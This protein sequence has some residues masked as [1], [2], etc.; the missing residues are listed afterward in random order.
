ARLFCLVA[1]ILSNTIYQ[2][3]LSQDTAPRIVINSVGHSGK[4][5]NV[6]YTPDGTRIIS[7]S[8]DKSIRIWD[9]KSGELLNK[10]ES[11]IGTGPKGMLYTSA[12]TPDGNILAVSGYPVNDDADNYIIFIDLNTGKQVSTAIG[13][14]NVINTLD[15]TGDGKYLASGSDDGTIRIWQ[16]SNDEETKSI[17]QID[18]GSRVANLS[19]NKKTNALVVASESKNLKLYN[20]AGLSNGGSNFEPRELKKHKDVLNKV[21]FSP[22]GSFIASSSFAQ[23]LILWR[24]DGSYVKSLDTD[25]KVVNALA[26][27]H[28]SRILVAMD[29]TGKG[30]SFN[31]PSGNKLSTFTGHDNTVFS[32]AFSPNSASG[33]YLACTAGGNNNVLKIWN[34]INGK[35][36][37]TIKGKGSVVWDLQFGEN[38]DL[39]LKKDPD[40]KGFDY[41]FDFKNFSIRKNPESPRSSYSKAANSSLAQLS[42]YQIE[43]NRRGLIQ[44]N[45]FEDGRI[46]DFQGTATGN[47]VVASDFSLKL[48][49]SQGLLLKEFLGH[50][51]GVRTVTVSKDGRYMASGGEDQTIKIW[52]LEEPGKIPSIKDV[53]QSAEWT[54]YFNQYDLGDLTT[55]NTTDAWKKTIAKIEAAGDRT[56]RD[57]QSVFDNLGESVKPFANLF[58][59]NDSEWISW[60]PTGYFNCSSAGGQYFGW[61]INRG[62]RQ[63]AD[64]YTAEQYFEILYRPKV[65]MRSINE[66]KRVDLI[67]A[68]EGEQL[69]DLG[70]LERPSAAFFNLSEATIGKNKILDYQDGSYQT[71]AKSINLEVD[72]YNGGGGLKELNIYQNNKLIITD[73]ELGKVSIGNTIKKFYDVNLVNGANEFKVIVKNTQKIESRANEINILYNGDVVASSDLFIL[74]V[75]INEYKNS[76]YDLN[77]AQPDAKSFVDKITERSGKIFRNVRKLEIYDKEATKDN[78]QIAFKSIVTQAKPEDVFVFYYAGHGTLDED[79]DDE[80]YLVPTDITKLYGDPEQLQAKGISA[81]GLKGMLAELKPQKQLILMDACHSGGAL[82]SIKTRAPASE[83]K[84]IVQLA[85]ASGVVMIASSGTQQYASEFEVLEHGV[86]TYSLLEALDGKLGMLDN[87]IMVGALKS[88]MEFRVPELAEEH[89]GKAQYPT[90]YTQGNDFPIGIIEK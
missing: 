83:E 54:E 32:A 57:L 9:A 10:Y 14:D 16:F 58:V 11:E 31:I 74:A 23:D 59:S 56:S 12:I 6:L 50:T 37:R 47:V 80:Y 20:L 5:F 77:Y 13:H 42:P 38:L 63:L 27:S 66:S 35:V 1:F 87:R 76:A 60:V 61:H 82:K 3:C 73:Q 85:R 34:P 84:A 68:D 65:L 8:E 7:V 18:V 55:E 17:H 26:F 30:V 41:S 52:K 69:F 86:F 21:S 15:F 64:F 70:K 4:V 46:L 49:S 90:G 36:Q 19:F 79:N 81:T 51:A 67:L 2:N 44:N 40:T 22:D 62:I 78:I 48:Y 29:E 24:A 28:D 89:G 53:F 72:L 71:K 43:V 45:E 25:D 39:Y 33:S 88:Y 75:G